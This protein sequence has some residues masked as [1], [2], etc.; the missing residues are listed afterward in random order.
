MSLR[1]IFDW[2]S[3]AHPLIYTVLFDD[4]LCLKNFLR[5]SNE[6]VTVSRR[7]LNLVS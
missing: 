6:Q 1:S 5:N 2:L 3:M 7:L 4:H